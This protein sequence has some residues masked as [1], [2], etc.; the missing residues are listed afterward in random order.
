MNPLARPTVGTLV[1]AASGR[2]EI[3]GR[4]M[5]ETKIDDGGPAFPVPDTYHPNGQVQFGSNGISAR[6]WFA[7]QALSGLIRSAMYGAELQRIFDHSG[8][9]A[10]SGAD[11]E[12]PQEYTARI[13]LSLADAM[14]KARAAR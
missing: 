7:G 2:G 12:T 11:G 9:V 4:A 3:E 6:D 13:A 5:S 14:L 10:D 8:K 1:V